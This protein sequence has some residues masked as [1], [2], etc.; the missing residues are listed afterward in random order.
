MRKKTTLLIAIAVVMIVAGA[1]IAPVKAY[2]THHMKAVGT[3][4]VNLGDKTQLHEDVD[5]WNKSVTIESHGPESVYVR[6]KAFASEDLT[7][8]YSGN[9]WSIGDQGYYYYS[10]ILD[11][12]M[13][14]S[15]L[16]VAISNVPADA[17]D[18][19]SLNVSIIYECTKVQYD[20]NGEPLAPDWS[21]AVREE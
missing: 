15:P 11:A 4:E 16:K 2:F 7:L 9:G 10:E 17:K 20:E 5:G 3:V 19:D 14:S 6:V 21:Q 13:T 1:S 12:G 18:G 8:S